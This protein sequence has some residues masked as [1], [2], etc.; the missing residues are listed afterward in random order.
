MQNARQVKVHTIKYTM[1][2]GYILVS[3]GMGSEAGYSKKSGLSIKK[4]NT[5]PTLPYYKLALTFSSILRKSRLPS[6]QQRWLSKK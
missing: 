4:F 5:K 3:G 1:L 6:M 2:V